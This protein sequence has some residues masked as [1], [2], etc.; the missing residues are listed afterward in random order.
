MMKDSTKVWEKGLD[1]VLD[2]MVSVF[3]KSI[4]S[5]AETFAKFSNSDT[6]NAQALEIALYKSVMTL[7]ESNRATI[8]QRLGPVQGMNLIHSLED[9]AIMDVT[10]N[11]VEDMEANWDNLPTE[12]QD[13]ITEL[14][15]NLKIKK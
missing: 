14:K 11:V 3:R 7:N 12:V 5:D 8:F 15:K 2:E 6:V 13:L 4:I 10:M 9:R 1:V